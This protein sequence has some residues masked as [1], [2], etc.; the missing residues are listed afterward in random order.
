[1]LTLTLNNTATNDPCALCGERTDPVVGWEVFPEEGDVQAPVC[2]ACV[3]QRAPELIAARIVANV[4]EQFE[5]HQV[6]EA[7][8]AIEEVC[9]TLYNPAATDEA[10][11]AA[12]KQF[13]A[14][15]RV[16]Y[17]PFAARL[18]LESVAHAHCNP[19][20]LASALRAFD[21]MRGID[22]NAIPY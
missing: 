11:V 18:V 6:A 20:Q 13:K 9:D 21:Q 14:L 8:Q 22:C 1:M 16:A 17:L 2:D 4:K 5:T 19:Q 12:V 10:V 7:V 3:R 15:Q